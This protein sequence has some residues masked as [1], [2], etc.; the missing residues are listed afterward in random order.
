MVV[1]RVGVV[2]HAAW[3]RTGGA[4][5][6]GQATEVGFV[7]IYRRWSR[8]QGTGRFASDID[9]GE[10]PWAVDGTIPYPLP[11]TTLAGMGWPNVMDPSSPTAPL[12]ISMIDTPDFGTLYDRSFR[13]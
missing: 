10:G 8:T 7:Q 6:P 2:L 12:G 3:Q 1:P 4:F 11:D 13:Q 9:V 5:S